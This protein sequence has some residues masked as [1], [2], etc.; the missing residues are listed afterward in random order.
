M[1][2]LS[3]CKVLVDPSGNYELDIEKEEVREAVKPWIP[4]E[5]AGECG[6]S[7]CHGP[8]ECGEP[9]TACTMQYELGDFCRE[10]A[11][12]EL[13]ESGC[14]LVPTNRYQVCR[15]CI[16]SCVQDESAIAAFDCEAQCRS[17]LEK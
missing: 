14:S 2:F 12:C 9:V 17:Q 13:S 11:T 15:T 3:G 7:N 1:V 6:V 8:V 4:K 5:E 10:Y 16:E